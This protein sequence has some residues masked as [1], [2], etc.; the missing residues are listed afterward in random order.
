V[1]SEGDALGSELA[2]RALLA[3]LGKK[4]IIV[5]DDPVPEEYRFLPGAAGIRLF[6][7]ARGA[8]F[9]CLVTLDCSDA[10]RAG[11]VCSLNTQGR[12]TLNIDH[13]VSNLMFAD[14][15]WVEPDFS[16][17]C[18]LIYRLYKALDVPFDRESA[19]NLYAGI[20]TDTG[21]FRFPNTSAGTHSAVADLMRFPLGVS[22][23]YRRIYESVPYEDIRFLASVYPSIKRDAGGKVVWF[24]IKE[25]AI[26]RARLSCDLSERVLSFGRSIRGVEVVAL[27]K[28][29]GGEKPRV[30]VNLRSQGGVDVNAVASLFGGGGHRTAS[31]A[32][33]PGTLK[34]V[35]RKVLAV[36]RARARST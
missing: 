5:N 21:S 12:P 30:R 26:R 2:F 36:I 15:N 11:R 4:G 33:V 23:L 13:H 29:I 27:F 9:Q 17:C 31:G 22:A 20:M 25:A 8:A 6:D 24:E 3:K 32:T 10:Q 28:E 34:A 16:S 35:S 1:N 18:E 7:D 14:T 19:L